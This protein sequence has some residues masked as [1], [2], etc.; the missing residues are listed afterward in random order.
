MTDHF[1]EQHMARSIKTDVERNITFPMEADEE[2]HMVCA[3]R[4]YEIEKPSIH[5]S[6]YLD[7]LIE[8]KKKDSF[9]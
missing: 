9:S 6:S 3:I 7:E 1:E 4:P 2:R 8:S 5:K